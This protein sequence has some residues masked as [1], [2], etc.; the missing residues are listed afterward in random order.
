MEAITNGLK[1]KMI[2]TPKGLVYLF[3]IEANQI[4]LAAQY[5]DFSIDTGIKS[6]D[7]YV[8]NRLDIA[9]NRKNGY[10]WSE[11]FQGF[12][13]IRSFA[14]AAKDDIVEQRYTPKV[15]EFIVAAIKSYIPKG[16]K[17]EIKETVV[18]TKDVTAEMIVPQG[19]SGNELRRNKLAEIGIGK[20]IDDYS[21]M[22][23]DEEKPT[24]INQK[25]IE[26]LAADLD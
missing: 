23:D 2:K 22:L 21:S 17:A 6:V 12:E 10:F 26:E 11:T 13:E 15:R 4:A 1:N 20:S 3:I 8:N 5:A 19:V 16:E 24:K 14:R 7:V 18:V 25:S 9:F